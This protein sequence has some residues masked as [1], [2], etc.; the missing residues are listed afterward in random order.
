[1]PSIATPYP[2]GM[3]SDGQ[4]LRDGFSREILNARYRDGRWHV[5]EGSQD[6]LTATSHHTSVFQDERSKQ[7]LSNLPTDPATGKVRL[8]EVIGLHVYRR[9]GVC[10]ITIAV[11]RIV[12]SDKALEVI[13]FRGRHQ[14]TTPESAAI[15]SGD[16]IGDRHVCI[17]EL[18]RSVYM[19]GPFM[20]GIYRIN[21]PTSDQ[22]DMG[23]LEPRQRNLNRNL[24]FDDPDIYLVDSPVFRYMVV[25]KNRIRGVDENNPDVLRS[26]NFA[27]GDAY[28]G[29]NFDRHQDGGNITGLASFGR[30]FVLFKSSRIFL[31]AGDPATA[32]AAGFTEL[33]TPYR[34][35]CVSHHSIT[36]TPHGLVFLG[37]YG[38]YLLHRNPTNRSIGVT[39]LTDGNDH[40]FSE[41]RPRTDAVPL[42]K[43]VRIFMEGRENSSGVYVPQSDMVCISTPSQLPEDYGEDGPL[44]TKSTPS[45]GLCYSF[46][47]PSQEHWGGLHVDTKRLAYAMCIDLEPDGRTR[48]YAGGHAGTIRLMDVGDGDRI[49][50]LGGSFNVTKYIQ[51]SMLVTVLVENPDGERISLN[52]V[53]VD[54]E[55]AYCDS[56]PTLV[57]QA[58]NHQFSSSS[59]TDSVNERQ[60]AYPYRG[61]SVGLN[62]AETPIR[63]RATERLGAHIGSRASQGRSVALSLLI[64]GSLV[65]I[66]LNVASLKSHVGN[67]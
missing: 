66:R 29:L 39:K 48:W 4:F 14:I 43:S 40:I 12:G 59:D 1:M 49:E 21:I 19:C 32:Q 18:G 60:I 24:S 27:D 6:L 64:P 63:L 46:G 53:N 16:V 42:E 65:R 20:R 22:I 67:D 25:H 35:G 41:A 8:G 55:R 52:G 15:Y 47:G 17:A 34:D 61:K 44:G 50:R 5:R 58:D 26:S 11:C 57:V 30:N 3:R 45:I 28:P 31:S 37:S 54:W 2:K 51:P 23:Y 33:E 62:N 36:R 56:G 7:S 13:L 9:R 38:L 10:P